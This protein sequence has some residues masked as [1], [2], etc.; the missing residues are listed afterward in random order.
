MDERYHRWRNT[1]EPGQTCFVTT[2]CL[3]FAHLFARL[4]MRTLMALHFPNDCQRHDARVH[5]FVVMTH[6]IHF[7]V[8]PNATQTIS[9]LVQQIK[10][11]SAKDLR[12]QLVTQELNQLRQQVGL[13][14]NRFWRDGFRGNPMVAPDV[15]QQKRHYIHLN[16]VRSGFVKD[17]ADYIW[18]SYFLLA[19]EM[20]DEDNGVDLIKAIQFYE[21]QLATGK[22]D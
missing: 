20:F 4:E 3:D 14:D 22:S 9:Y 2:T 10:R 13:N 19:N 1:K 8:T 11:R 6:H 5:T 15:F 7:L 16:P 21:S 12:C 17:P 18:S